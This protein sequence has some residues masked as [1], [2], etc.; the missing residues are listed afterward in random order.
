MDISCEQRTYKSILDFVFKYVYT[1]T[2]QERL[3]KYGLLK[4]NMNEIV[5]DGK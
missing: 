3:D 2:Y 4:D 1:D 5:L